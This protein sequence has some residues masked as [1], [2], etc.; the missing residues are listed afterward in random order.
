MVRLFIIQNSFLIT[1][2]LN[3]SDK[4][5]SG[6]GNIAGFIF[7]ALFRVTPLLLRRH[8]HMHNERVNYSLR[9]EANNN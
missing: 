8:L 6:G 5:E 2:R 9:W 7:N 1:N 3:L 4:V